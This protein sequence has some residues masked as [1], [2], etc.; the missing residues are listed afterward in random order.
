MV[1]ILDGVN[2]QHFGPLLRPK[3]CFQK[4]KKWCR[5]KIDQHFGWG[6]TRTSLKLPHSALKEWRL[7]LPAAVL[8]SG[9]VSRRGATG[10]TL[11]SARGRT[12]HVLPSD[13]VLPC[14][15]RGRR[16]P[17]PP[18]AWSESLVQQR[19]VSSGLTWSRV[20]GELLA[21]QLLVPS[22]AVR[23]FLSLLQ[24]FFCIVHSME[25]LVCGSRAF[26]P[27]REVM[28]LPC[29]AASVGRRRS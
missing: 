13:D 29:P 23:R 22:R 12:I 9:S 4:L 10:G 2:F 11:G 1:K 14:H 24:C 6:K 21:G 8:G 20:F 7:G 25:T 28:P 3:M 16:V 5:P 17:L 18:R 19:R 15:P 27:F 26:H